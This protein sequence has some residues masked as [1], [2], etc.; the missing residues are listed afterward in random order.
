MAIVINDDEFCP[1]CGAFVPYLHE[2]TGFCY[3]CSG[4]EPTRRC[5]GCNNI[6]GDDHEGNECWRCKYRRWL[7]RN[8]DNIE[9]VMVTNGVKASKA[10]RI[11]LASNRP[12]CL[13]CREP[14][15]G[16]QIG[17]HFFC[18][19]NKICRKAST[20]YRYHRTK[21]KSHDEAIKKAIEAAYIIKLTGGING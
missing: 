12:I 20:T 19:T 4:I 7:E 14:I 17:K 21:N 11:V 2:E 15:K 13:S 6:L 5:S 16:G 3:S 1:N 8:A 10:K 9:R 18:R